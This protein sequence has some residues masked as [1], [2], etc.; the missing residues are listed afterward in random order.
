MR[1]PTRAILGAAV[2]LAATGLP[3][4]PITVRVDAHPA[5][6]RPISPLIYGV[7]SFQDT[8]A[9]M[10]GL[11]ASIGR[12]GGNLASSYNWRLN[13]ANH[14]ADWYFLSQPRPGD[15]R[16]AGYLIDLVEQHRAA[17]AQSMVS[18]PMLR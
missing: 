1:A 7:S 5:Q 12:W 16:P 9:V 10:R 15:A 13:A 6:R 18:V 4:A 17:A 11:N 3:A 2:L 8:A 14:A